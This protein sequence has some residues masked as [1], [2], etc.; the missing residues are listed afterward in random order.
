MEHLKA[1]YLDKA[2]R[3]GR[4][5]RQKSQFYITKIQDVAVFS[6]PNVASHQNS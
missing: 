2:E 5:S 3:Q 4:F 6:S 1:R